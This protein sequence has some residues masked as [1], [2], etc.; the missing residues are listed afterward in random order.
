MKKLVCVNSLTR[1]EGHGGITVEVR[2]DGS[3]GVVR[4]DVFEGMRLIEPLLKGRSYEEV[5]PIAS[6]ICAICSVS[7]TLASLAATES[8]F[9]ISVSDRTHRMRE[10]LCR[11]EHIASHSLHL[12]ALALPDYLNYPGII[13]MAKDHASTVNLGLRLK[14]L[15]NAIQETVGGRAVHPVNAVVGGFGSP[16]DFEQLV[17]L[18]AGL[19][20][21]REDCNAMIE[22]V[23]RLPRLEFC[24]GGAVFSALDCRDNYQYS[25]VPAV[26]VLDGSIRE[27]FKGSDY[28][29]A[30][31]EV[32]VGHSHARHSTYRGKPFMVGAL[33]R[34]VINRHLLPPVAGEACSMLGEWIPSGDPMGNNFAQ[35]VEILADVE[36]C[37]EIVKELLSEDTDAEVPV[38]VQPTAGVGTGVIEAPRGLLFHQYSYDDSGR[39]LKADV[40]TPTALNAASIEEH[41]RQAVRMDR[42]NGP[43]LETRLQMIA[44]AYDPCISC[45]V[46]LI[47]R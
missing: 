3:P 45:S 9:G 22:L 40:I 47:W 2:E 6:R 30:L 27:Q 46:H 4:F 16:P 18:R 13:A 5:A 21:A 24:S 32:S 37:L 11:G 42:G 33:A 17:Q 25:G 26:A 39:L 31:R 19:E 35:A 38:P 7:H 10:L 43:S 12:F 28:R 29:T 8:A 41:F 23:A 34:V 15:G 20:E 36:R 44:R 14:K 1:V